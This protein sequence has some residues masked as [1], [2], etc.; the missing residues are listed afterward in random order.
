[1]SV[2]NLLR[3]GGD[4]LSGFRF[5]ALNGKTQ[6]A[7]DGERCQHAESAGH[8]EHDGVEIFLSEFVVLQQHTAVGVHVGPG[9]L[10]LSVLGEN[11][12]SNLVDEA[13]KIDKLVVLDVLLAELT[14]A[15][16]AGVGLAQNSVPITGHNLA[17]VEGVPKRFFHGVLGEATGS[18]VL[19]AELLD[20]NQN[21]LIGQAV[22]GAGQSVHSGGEGQVG[23]TEGRTNQVSGVGRHVAALVVRVDGQVH[24]HDLVEH[25]VLKAKHVGKVGGPVKL[26]LWG[27]DFAA[28]VSV[29]VDEGGHTRQLC[30]AVH[31]VLK[32]ELPVIL[33]VDTVAIRLS[34]LG[35]LL[36][37]HDAD[38]QGG[39]G[40]HG[41]GQRKDEV[42]HPRGNVGARRPLG[43]QALDLS[44][45]RDFAGKEQPEHAFGQGLAAGLGGGEKLLALRDGVAPETN[46]FL[47]VEQRG[48]GNH[49]QHAAHATIGLIHSAGSNDDVFVLIKTS[50]LFCLQ[51]G[52]GGGKTLVQRGLRGKASGADDAGQTKNGTVHNDGVIVVQVAGSCSFWELAP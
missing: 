20:P 3:N 41:L 21:L 51:L 15:G 14:L 31:G 35:V 49:G 44:G 8:A 38:G 1:M 37:G 27:D 18:L 26:F 52:N 7:V 29:A 36:Q 5:G 40:V 10:G 42:L 4:A 28:M 33:L 47:G 24:A 39:H 9:V 46:A 50:L 11:A 22:E 16:K 34:K 32:G 48:L 12:G 2:Q 25:G 6:G 45:G 19:V 23:V 30:D 13:H 43:A 17:A